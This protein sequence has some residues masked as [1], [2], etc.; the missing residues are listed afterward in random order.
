MKQT[1]LV[2]NKNSQNFYAEQILKTLGAQ[3]KGS[4]SSNAGIEVLHAF[5]KKLGFFS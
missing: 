3:I 2:M 1:I 4:G 5:M